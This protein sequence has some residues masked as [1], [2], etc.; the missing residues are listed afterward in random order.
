M[1]TSNLARHWVHSHEEDTASTMVFRPSAY[2][3]PRSRG[4]AAFE[5]QADGSMIDHGLG[6]A[7]VS[8]AKPGQWSVENNELAFFHGPQKKPVR[9]LKIVTCDT[10]KLVVQKSDH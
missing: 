4:R 1:P 2:A 6:P 3:F 9:V 10:D 8:V 5:L 7:D